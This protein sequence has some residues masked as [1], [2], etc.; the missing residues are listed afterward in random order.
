MKQPEKTNP[1]AEGRG[2]LNLFAACLRR[3]LT[4]A[5]LS[6]FSFF[7]LSCAPGAPDLRTV[8]S[9]ANAPRLKPDYSGIVIPANIAPLNFKIQEQGT[10]FLARIF[11]AH[12]DTISLSNK[13]GIVR[14]PEA[15]WARLLSANQGEQ[16]VLQIYKKDQTGTWSAFRPVRDTIASNDIDRYLVYR[17]ID[18]LYRLWDNMGIYQRDLSS[19]GETAILENATLLS[20]SQDKFDTPVT[21]SCVNCHTFFNKSS[22][23][24]V[25]HM[26]SG[27]GIGML[28]VN[29][30]KITK[31]DTRTLFNKSPG[32]YSAW[33]PSGTL[34]AMTIMSVHQFFHAVGRTRDVIDTKS[35]II[36]Y[37]IA[38][39]TVK[40]GPLIASAT[41]METYPEW[42]PDGKYLY[43]CSA[44][45]IDSSF[46]IYGKDAGYANIKYSLMRIPYDIS[47]NTW[48]RLDTVLSC[49]DTK[50]SISHPKLSPD[51]RYVVFCMSNYGNFPIH[52]PESDLFLLDLSTKKYRRMEINSNFTESYHSWSGN[53]RWLVF[54]TKRDSSTCARP[55]FSYFDESGVAHKPFVL[56]QKDPDFYDSYLKTYNVPELVSKPVPA[57]WRDLVRAAQGKFGVIKARLDSRVPLD[58]TTGSTP[59]ARRLTG[60]PY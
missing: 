34:L 16:L 3:I 1:V 2:E 57:R 58:G 15:Q 8:V 11:S 44:P 42:S 31:I 18:P 4:F 45:Q 55:Y 14:I 47:T 25:I 49:A 17:L 40:T 12:G 56:P 32:A 52:A 60:E 59:V 43:F 9:L 13:N 30:G 19:F 48:G 33:H 36:L 41:N 54:S 6:S 46:T 5:F 39:N 28:L 24:M 10:F 26:R 23:K 51:G 50:M 53:G 20:R 21:K 35:D 22:D 37:D 29:N 38:A 7:H 27:S